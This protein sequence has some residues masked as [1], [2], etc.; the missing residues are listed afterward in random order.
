MLRAIG[1]DVSSRDVPGLIDAFGW[2]STMRD[3]EE[4][5]EAGLINIP[6]DI[7]AAA[8][9]D[10]EALSDYESVV[11]KEAVVR[12]MSEE[13]LIARQS[14]DAADASLADMG[15]QPGGRVLKM[16]SASIRRFADRTFPRRFPSAEVDLVSA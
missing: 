6:A 9:L 5:L 12:W 8:G 15:Q 11:S 16:F 13:L 2:C 4:D 14:L 1:S 3:L 10:P 7:I